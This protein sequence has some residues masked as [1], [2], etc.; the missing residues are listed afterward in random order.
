M[1][2][3][4]SFTD[5]KDKTVLFEGGKVPAKGEEAYHT[6]ETR[7]IIFA[8]MAVGINKITEENAPLF[9]ERYVAIMQAMGEQERFWGFTE[10]DVKNHIGLATNASR[11]SPTAFKKQLKQRAEKGIFG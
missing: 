9:W 10:Q 6:N 11:L 7:N 1:S 4:F 3:N 2:L 5:I 8:T